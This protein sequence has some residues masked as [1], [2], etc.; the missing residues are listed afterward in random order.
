MKNNENP[1]WKI[2]P[3]QWRLF[4][5]VLILGF[6]GLAYSILKGVHIEES[7]ALYVGLPLLLALGLSL[8]PRCKSAK[9]ATMKGITIALLLSALVFKEGYICILFAAPIFYG[10]GLIISALVDYSRAKRDKNT[11]I[12]SAA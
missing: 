7:A 6:A 3:D 10:V 8:T 11:T 12:R 1:K 9:G 2:S 4:F 5:V